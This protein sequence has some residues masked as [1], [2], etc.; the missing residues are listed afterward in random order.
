[1]DSD[2]WKNRFGKILK[3]IFF[4]YDLDYKIFSDKYQVH[5]STVRY[6]FSGRSFPRN[7]SWESLKKYL[8]HNVK[9]ELRKDTDVYEKI[10]EYIGIENIE[11]YRKMKTTYV[12]ISDFLIEVLQ[13]C[14][15]KGKNC[16]SNSDVSVELR[17]S[18]RTQVVVF[19]FDGTLTLQKSNITIWENIWIKLGYD[20]KECRDLQKMFIQKEITYK[21]WCDRTENKFLIKNL[22][23]DDIESIANNIK[24][25]PGV[26]ETFKMLGQKGIKIYIVSGSIL[27]II[28]R[29]LGDLYQF[30]DGI[31][32]NQFW[33]NE[34][35]FLDR[36]VGTKYDFEYKADF[37]SGLSIDLQISPK[38]ILFVGNSLNDRF[39]HKSGA[40]TLCIN[41]ILADISDSLAWNDY[42]RDC[43]DLREILKYLNE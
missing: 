38:D 36:I 30:I 15:H 11:D 39:V 33:F 41:P 3:Y 2:I 9:S 26:D 18:Q 32:A 25:L 10:K 35:G 12:L 29:V 31:S 20:V 34:S 21:E 1:M 5:T 22:H 16:F 37:I 43:K 27:L 7:Y 28:Q 40:K 4:V 24:L 14:I 13:F 42:I 6:W 17:E 8:L 23:R 19:D